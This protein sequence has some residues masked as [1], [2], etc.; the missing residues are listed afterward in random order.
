MHS[1]SLPDSRGFKGKA[2]A[3]DVLPLPFWEPL[4]PRVRGLSS[5]VRRRLVKRHAVQHLTD[6]AI[7]GVNRLAWGPQGL[8]PSFS[9]PFS[10]QREAL[11]RIAGACRE[12]GPPPAELDAKAAL[13]E[14]RGCTPYEE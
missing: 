2:A 14:L 1:A 11:R 5:S 6:E 9:A 10:A 4:V 8:P 3:S 7:S 12:M 13:E